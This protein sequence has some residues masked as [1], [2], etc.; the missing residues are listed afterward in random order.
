MHA[1]TVCVSCYSC[2]ILFD[3][4]FR[5]Y[6]RLNFPVGVCVRKYH[7]VTLM[8]VV[9]QTS[10]CDFQVAGKLGQEKKKNK[11]VKFIEATDEVSIETAN[12]EC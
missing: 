3:D 2:V 8:L 7:T 11:G 6:S 1:S 9:H 10:R 5:N 4:W 12:I